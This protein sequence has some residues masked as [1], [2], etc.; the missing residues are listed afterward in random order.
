[1]SIHTLHRHPNK[2]VLTEIRW[3]AIYVEPVTEF[4][5]G[6]RDGAPT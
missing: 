2:K 5:L 1:M 4:A 3:A 6:E